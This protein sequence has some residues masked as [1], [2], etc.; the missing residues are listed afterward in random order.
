[1]RSKLSAALGCAL[2][3]Q[4][5][6]APVGAAPSFAQAERARAAAHYIVTQQVPRGRP[7]AGSFR[8]SLSPLG[9]AADAVLALAAA[10]VGGDAIDRAIAYIKAR[11][12]SATLGQK[13]K[14]VMALV[15]ARR[16][17]R[18]FA[19]RN[20]VR[21]IA[22]ALREDG[23]Y[24]GAGSR[25]SEVFDHVLSMLALAAAR[26]AIPASA[27]SW[28]ARAQCR[29]G[30][31]QF[32]DPSAADD[33][34]HCRDRAAPGGDAITSDTN[35]TAYAVMALRARRPVPALRADPFVFLAS[36]R[37]PHKGGWVYD[38]SNKCRSVPS[39]D[40]CWLTDANSTSLA[41][42]AHAA[43]RKRLP[44]GA[45]AA[46]RRL[47]Y[48]RCGR[49]GGAFDFTYDPATGRLPAEREGRNLAATVAAVP[50]LL[51]KALP[52]PAARVAKR[53]RP[54]RPC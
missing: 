4:L 50:A 28:L 26:S 30:G 15:A 1:M 6:A 7:H 27:A 22:G 45:L 39:N 17:P 19:R 32:D 23:Q 14:I 36:G 49:L 18:R 25:S 46:L 9:T 3:V 31:W 41:I 52:I 48:R 24:A 44:A 13:A 5:A 34:E 53:A 29:D 10:G 35:T 43:A 40:F 33:D 11:M 38:P 47:Q 54:P 2:S 42:L 20:L 12:A 37:D 21:Q 16:N 51:Q 8:G